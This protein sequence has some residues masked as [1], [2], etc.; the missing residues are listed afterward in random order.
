MTIFWHNSIFM[1]LTCKHNNNLFLSFKTA[2]QSN[3]TSFHVEETYTISSTSSI[4]HTRVIINQSRLD[5]LSQKFNDD[6]TQWSIVVISIDCTQMHV[7][8]QLYCSTS[9][10]FLFFRLLNSTTSLIFTPCSVDISL[11]IFCTMYIVSIRWNNNSKQIPLD[12]DPAKACRFLSNR[13]V[14]RCTLVES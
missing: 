7:I 9:V 4:K 3:Q 6:P 14:K 5:S 12:S 2:S 10:S 1:Y 8:E 13:H 11:Y